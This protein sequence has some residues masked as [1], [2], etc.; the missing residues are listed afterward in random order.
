M[1]LLIKTN[2]Y[3]PSHAD[4]Q[5][6]YEAIPLLKSTMVSLYDFVRCLYYC[7]GKVW[8]VCKCLNNFSICF[9]NWIVNN[10]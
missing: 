9:F 10:S 1:W 3:N 8:N 2:D 7:L 4:E 6:N 5:H